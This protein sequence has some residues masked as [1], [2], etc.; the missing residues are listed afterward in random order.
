MIVVVSGEGYCDL[1]LSKIPVPLLQSPSINITPNPVH[2]GEGLMITGSHFN[3]T[4]YPGDPYPTAILYMV[5]PGHDPIV[6]NTGKIQQD[7]SCTFSTMI[8][9][10]AA[11]EAYQV[12]CQDKWGHKSNTI[13]LTIIP[14]VSPTPTPGPVT[15]TPVQNTATLTPT[16]NPQSTTTPQ[17]VATVSPTAIT[18]GN[19]DTT[20]PVTT[21]SLTGG[22]NSAGEFTSNVVCT[23]TVMDN[24][25][26]TGIGETKYSM[27]GVNWTTYSEPFT[28][29]TPGNTTVFYRSTDLAG[30]KELT[31]SETIAIVNNSSGS[32]SSGICPAL[33]LPLLLVVIAG[34]A[35]VRRR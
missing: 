9:S 34:A 25:G 14:A 35:R 13:T 7:G 16:Q 11:I 19:P 23:L 26:G 20:A 31:K 30:N 8:A 24:E 22:K 2:T 3:T 33:I 17:T 5:L 12:Y 29:T 21:I 6:Y 28:I 1:K 15:P 32:H 18:N 4:T 10:Y 27:D